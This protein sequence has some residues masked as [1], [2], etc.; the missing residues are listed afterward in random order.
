MTTDVV[1]A[2]QNGNFEQQN[3]VARGTRSGLQGHGRG[4][5]P[6]SHVQRFITF[7]D[8]LTPNPN[9]DGSPNKLIEIIT[10]EISWDTCMDIHHESGFSVVSVQHLETLSHDPTL[11]ASSS[12]SHIA[13][14]KVHVHTFSGSPPPTIR[15]SIPIN[16][17]QAFKNLDPSHLILVDKLSEILHISSS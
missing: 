15:S 11:L 17:G 4:G 9:H 12:Q 6:A 16:I 13:R 8:D 14:G 7:E 3:P 2:D 5:S 1:V 10:P